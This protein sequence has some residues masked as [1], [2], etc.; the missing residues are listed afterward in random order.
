MHFVR[1]F[2]QF[3]MANWLSAVLSPA[4]GRSNESI[5]REAG[6]LLQIDRR[7]LPATAEQRKLLEKIFSG[8]NLFA[9]LYDDDIIE[10]DCTYGR[11]A[12]IVREMT[13]S[14]PYPVGMTHWR[15]RFRIV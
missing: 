1:Q 8:E 5:K 13:R 7:G 15:Y 9:V 11:A 14:K 3:D 10:K 6:K 4:P 12:K 2:T